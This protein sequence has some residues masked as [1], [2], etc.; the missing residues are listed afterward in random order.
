MQQRDNNTIR[1]NSNHTSV[2]STRLLLFVLVMLEII[3]IM[4]SFLAGL[5]FAPKEK[6]G[7]VG[8][9]QYPIIRI[10]A[11]GSRY[12]KEITEAVGK[13]NDIAPIF[14]ITST[15]DNADITCYDFEEG[16][17]GNTGTVGC[18]QE[19]GRVGFNAHLMS[20]DTEGKILSVALHEL[21][22]VVGLEH[23]NEKG[24]VMNSKNNP[25]NLSKTD[26]ARVKYIYNQNTKEDKGK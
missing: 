13:Y 14:A 17:K 18:T 2:V 16:M 26:I 19:N 22:H 1:R 24:S 12:E 4:L 23:N 15:V 25:V 20:D 10:Y 6:T 21:G 8:K 5:T 11:K 7:W 3:L 9:T